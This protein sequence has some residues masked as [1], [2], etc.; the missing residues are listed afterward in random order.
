[1]NAL[2]FSLLV[3]LAGCLPGTFPSDPPDVDGDGYSE[4]D[5][6]CD[7]T[8]A[9][10][11]PATVWFEDVDDD[12]H[13]GPAN[14][15]TQCEAPAGFVLS[16]D[17]CDDA[18][19]D[20]RPG[21]VETCDG[22]D[23]D[24]DGVA[25]DGAPGS[26]KYYTDLDADGFGD[27]ATLQVSC[28][29]LSGRVTQGGDCDDQDKVSFPG[30]VEVCDKADNDC[31]ELVDD[32]P[33]DGTDWFVDADDDGFG[34]TETDKFCADPGAGYAATSDDCDDA[35]KLV[36]DFLVWYEDLDKDGYGDDAAVTKACDLP[37]DH[38]DKG[39]DCADADDTIHP[40]ADEVCD[41]VDQDC[42]TL[43]DDSPVDP[44]SWY[45]DADEDTYG[46][47]TE[48]VACTAPTNK[49]VD[50]DGDCNDLDEA[51]HPGAAETC[52]DT[53]DFNCDGTVGFVDADNDG[54]AACDDCDDADKDINPSATEICDAGSVDE[55]CSGLA[56]DLDSGVSDAT[57]TDWYHDGDDDTYGLTT[58]TTRKC[59]APVDYVAASGDCDDTVGAI[60][61]GATEVCDASNV[62]EDCDGS[63]DDLDTAPSG[64][65]LLY[66]DAD[67]DTHGDPSDSMSL[68]DATGGRVVTNDD[69][70]DGDANIHPGAPEVCD[71]VADDCGTGWSVSQ[72]VGLVTHFP[73]SGFASDLTSAW[74][75]GT[76]GAAAAITLPSSGRV[77][78][79]EGRYYVMISTAA[80][81][82][83]EVHGATKLTTFLD[84]EGSTGRVFTV[85]SGA[86]ADVADLTILNGTGGA[87]VLG[88]ASFTRVSIRDNIA[89][90][91]GGID[92]TLGPTGLLRVDDSSLSNN[93]STGAGG[94]I[95]VS[96]GTLEVVNGAILLGNFADD[97]AGIHATGT[98]V[99]V[100]AATVRNNQADLDGGGVHA[101]TSSIA[102]SNGALIESNDAMGVGGGLLLDSSDL[103]CGA[104][105]LVSNSA[106]TGGG[107]HVFGT[108]D[109][110]SAACNWGVPLVDDNVPDDIVL[111]GTGVIGTYEANA[112]F[113]CSGTTC[114]P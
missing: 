55:D 75:A 109:V 45:L 79:C 10:V 72:E 25:D 3:A 37:V 56:D 16:D 88:N 77:E 60:N 103:T 76:L 51:Y 90:D 24:C 107:V 4:G 74:A 62:D 94:A 96:G 13:G 57:R 67:G 32:E 114:V 33:S 86:S 108:L 48:T 44:T 39:G 34:G 91:G 30:G 49:H 28:V 66:A 58:Q 38:V 87:S 61:P 70:D 31:N 71:G 85:A 69:C 73:T 29:V 101:T 89:A 19:A 113:A 17:D 99:V 52:T 7:D 20:I 104:S 93:R 11:N 110:T 64:R 78:V 83:V 35:D 40:S 46:D 6:D 80:S 98:S 36:G 105:S 2:R 14:S 42:D 84:A 54:F 63:A 5:G 27:D 50:R 81:G 59:D 8:N 68:C 18:D 100:D 22:V 43:I 95:R 23:E 47:G 21:A 102:L 15:V 26:D 82:S 111:E 106:T 12:A 65:T 53:E 41:G 1:M 97:G 9:A 112:T 92:A